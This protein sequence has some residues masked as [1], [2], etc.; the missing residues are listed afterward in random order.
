MTSRNLALETL[1][2]DIAQHQPLDYWED[3]GTYLD[4]LSYVFQH[5]VF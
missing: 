3:E 5:D 4:P 1:N 2:S